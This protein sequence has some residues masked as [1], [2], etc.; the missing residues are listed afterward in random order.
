MPQIWLR[1]PLITVSSA[2]PQC[3]RPADTFGDHQVGCGRNG[4]QVARHD[5]LRNAIFTAAQSAALG[6]RKE[7]YALIVGTQSRPADVFL[8]TWSR[9]R[10]AALDV[11]VTSPLQALTIQEAFTIAVHALEV[12]TYRKLA[13]HLSPCRAAGLDF[14][15][16]A[17]ETLDGCFRDAADTI[18]AIGQQKGQSLGTSSGS[19]HLFKRF[20]ITLWR[21][22]ANLW[23]NR[24]ITLLSHVDG[25][26]SFLFLFYFIFL[27]LLFIFSFFSGCFLYII[28]LLYCF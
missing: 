16:L 12:A 5:A 1:L 4:D 23:L 10:P 21:E 2:C 22:N 24:E 7:A 13:T 11:T 26:V 9:G 20:A 17:V 28:A 18:H 8:P 6:P 27:L 3:L 15:P 14:I 19:R 25:V